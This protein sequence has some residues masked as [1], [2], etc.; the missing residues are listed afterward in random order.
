MKIEKFAQTYLNF[1]NP[2]V[3]EV[4]QGYLIAGEVS[5]RNRCFWVNKQ[6]IEG[7]AEVAKILAIDSGF[8]AILSFIPGGSFAYRLIKDQIGYPPRYNIIF[9]PE[10]Y[11][12]T[13]SLITLD[14]KGQAKGTVDGLVQSID[15]IAKTAIKTGS[16]M[17]DAIVD[18][19][20]KGKT[21][22]KP[23]T[24]RSEYDETLGFTYLRFEDK[25]SIIRNKIVKE[26]LMDTKSTASRIAKTTTAGLTPSI[27][28]SF[29]T[30]ANA[31]AVGFLT[32][33]QKLGFN[34]NFSQALLDDK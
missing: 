34:V 21:K 10:F 20:T 33:L 32:Y 31:E 11:D 2:S 1:K 27:V 14:K 15:H 16:K 17:Q 13:Y 19:I 3:L 7:L 29:K 5:K 28:I 9:E 23:K 25:T 22:S 6:N 24:P 30:I 12:I 18:L 8:S 4:H 26:R